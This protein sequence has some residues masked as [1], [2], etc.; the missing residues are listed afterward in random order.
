MAVAA[1]EVETFERESLWQRFKDNLKSGNLG[2]WPVILALWTTVAMG[3][4]GAA[5][6]WRKLTSRGSK[7]LSA[8]RK[9]AFQTA[10]SLVVV[11]AL[12]A[13]AAPATKPGAASGNTTRRKRRKP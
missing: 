2:S 5:D 3:V 1:A 13:H 11:G 12:Y 10:I 8:K 4:L 7:G 6:D 9:L